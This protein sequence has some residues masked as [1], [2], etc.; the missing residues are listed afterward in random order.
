MLLKK[1]TVLDIAKARELTETTVWTHIERL[2][3]DG[4]LTTTEIKHLEPTTIDWGEA[5]QVLD[6]AMDEHGVEKLKPL[7]EAAGERYDYVLVR[8]ARMQYLLER[9]GRD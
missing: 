8:L 3:E 9:K 5:R 2:V 1:N 7:Y 4:E 6:A